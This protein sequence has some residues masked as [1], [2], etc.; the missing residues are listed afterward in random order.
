MKVKLP[1]RFTV[2]SWEGE[3]RITQVD[4]PRK[5]GRK[6]NLCSECGQ[7]M[8]REKK[9]NCPN[10]NEEI[11]CPNQDCNRHTGKSFTTMYNLERHLKRKH[12]PPQEFTCNTCGHSCTSK[13][14]LKQHERIRHP[15]TPRA[16]LE[17]QDC[18]FT[19][20]C[21][22]LLQ[23]HVNDKHTKAIW[24]SCPYCN[25]RNTSRYRH[26]RHQ[27]RCKAKY[28]TER[29]RY[30]PPKKKAKA[31][32][33]FVQNSHVDVEPH[34]AKATIDNI[35]EEKVVGVSEDDKLD[36]CQQQPKK[37]AETLPVVQNPELD[38]E[39]NV[40]KTTFDN[41]SAEE[42][43]SPDQDDRL[44]THILCNPDANKIIC[45]SALLTKFFG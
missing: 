25:F 27:R 6:R 42:Q 2:Q 26:N 12:A 45:G 38:V 22:A 24:Y 4:G 5:R 44:E 10:R 13:D 15:K 39:P 37:K 40:A 28:E 29:S 43:G 21:R 16:L 1:D 11:W 18:D 34:V 32:P 14:G 30:Q 20:V 17:C 9:H 3:M 23:D 19:A 33:S 41:F 7:H 35:S 31:L 36:Q 8:K